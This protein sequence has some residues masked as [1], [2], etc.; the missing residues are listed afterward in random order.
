MWDPETVRCFGC[1][2]FGH[3][4]AQCPTPPPHAPVAA[5]LDSAAW[6]P[7]PVPVRRTPEE[8]GNYAQWAARIRADMGWAGTERADRLRRHAQEQV[9]ESR[10]D[11][12]REMVPG[13]GSI[14]GDAR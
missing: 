7:P 4:K 6:L 8:I 12:F 5:A 1:G 2:E 10:M 13:N 3:L 11:P 9:R 14:P